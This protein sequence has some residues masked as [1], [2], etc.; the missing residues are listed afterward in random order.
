MKKSNQLNWRKRYGNIKV[1]KKQCAIAHQSVKGLCCVCLVRPSEQ[2]HHAKYGNDEI[3]LTVFPVCLN[4]HNQVC[5]SSKNWNKDKTR[6][7]WGNQ[8]TPEFIERLKL[9][10]KLLYGEIE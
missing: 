9:G 8:N 6:P 1:Y 4:C 3:G 10:Y 7:V 5:H 2:L